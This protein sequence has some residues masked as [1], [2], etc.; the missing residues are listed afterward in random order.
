MF[1]LPCLISAADRQK[2]L[3]RG[4]EQSSTKCR[5]GQALFKRHKY[6]DQHMLSIHHQ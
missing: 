3:I 6:I 5:E 1:V 2:N 4:K